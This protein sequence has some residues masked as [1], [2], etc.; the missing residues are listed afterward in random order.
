MTELRRKEEGRSSGEEGGG[1]LTAAKTLHTHSVYV[2][3][4]RVSACV[5]VLPVPTIRGSA[6]CLARIAASWVK[7]SS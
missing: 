7:V 4:V 3:C 2:A 1:S 6:K 5:C